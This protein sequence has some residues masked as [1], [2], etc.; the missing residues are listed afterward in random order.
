MGNNP[1]AFKECGDNCPV[2]SVSWFDA[3]EFVNALSRE[4]G[5][6][7]CYQINGEEVS[8]V[9]LDCAGFRLPTEAEWEYAARGAQGRE[10]PWGDEAPTPEHANYDATGKRST[11]PVKSFPKG[12]TPEGIHDMAGNVSEWCHDWWGRYPGDVQADPLGSDSGPARAFR[13]G[14]FSSTLR[15][16]PS[17]YRGLNPPGGR[18]FDLGFR[19]AWSSSRGLDK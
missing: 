3:L 6:E 17:K 2:E 15:F 16:L 13:G 4:E 8:F 9:G 5:L 11:M 19:V 12:A 10:Y 7:E 14:S 1:S 18:L